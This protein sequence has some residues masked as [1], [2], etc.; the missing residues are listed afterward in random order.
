[1]LISQQCLKAKEKP[2]GVRITI[3]I[4]EDDLNQI[5]DD[6]LLSLA[7]VN[8]I[9]G[10]K[11]KMPLTNGYTS[12]TA[13]NIDVDSTITQGAMQRQ[14]SLSFGYARYLDDQITVH[15]TGE[16]GSVGDEIIHKALTPIK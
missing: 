2:M 10:V 11:E 4:S 12:R 5:K 8:A 3:D 13:S 6:T 16:N 15:V 1:M 14:L 7:F 9:A